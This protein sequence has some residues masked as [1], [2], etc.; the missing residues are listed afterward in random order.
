MNDVCR[1]KRCSNTR[2]P[3]HRICEEH[4]EGRTCRHEHCLR[5]PVRKGLCAIHGSEP[6]TF[7]CRSCGKHTRASLIVKRCYRCFIK[8]SRCAFNGCNRAASKHSRRNKVWVGPGPNDYACKDDGYC[9]RHM[10]R[11]PCKFHECKSTSILRSREGFCR[12]HAA[13]KSETGSGVVATAPPK[14]L[15]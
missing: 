11:T 4:L 6:R 9:S 8:E 13:G 12:R 2:V 14:A 7:I 15:L 5:R 10:P 1:L 3:G